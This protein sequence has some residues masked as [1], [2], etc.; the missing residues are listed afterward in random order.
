M[1]TGVRVKAGGRGGGR[2]RKTGKWEEGKVRG[3]ERELAALSA[4]QCRTIQFSIS[5]EEQQVSELRPG[6]EEERERKKTKR[7][8]R[9]G[10]VEKTRG[11][12]GGS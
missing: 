2:E 1:T 3:R 8:G 7:C 6:E 10:K 12:E 4:V 9:K 5:N 11:R